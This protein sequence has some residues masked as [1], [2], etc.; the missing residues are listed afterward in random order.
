MGFICLYPG[1][2][3]CNIKYYS[4]VA[5]NTVTDGGGTEIVVDKVFYYLTLR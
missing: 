1:G 4:T 3:K 2:I 5:K